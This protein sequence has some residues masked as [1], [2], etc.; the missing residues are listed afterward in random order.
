M[1]PHRPSQEPTG[2]RRCATALPQ[3]G[4]APLA[5]AA[6]GLLW[7]AT[8]AAWPVIAAV[9]A[10]VAVALTV[11]GPRGRVVGLAALLS[12]LAGLPQAGRQREHRPARFLEGTAVVRHA[13]LPYRGQQ[14]VRV[15][16]DG[17]AGQAVELLLPLQWDG[18]GVAHGA[19]LRVTCRRDGRRRMR[20][21]SRS[22]WARLQAA[23]PLRRLLH[24]MRCQCARSFERH[25]PR[26][27]AAWARALLLGDR[28]ALPFPVVKQLRDT[29][30]GHLLAV[31]GLHVG[32]VLALVMAVLR[33]LPLSPPNQA[34]VALPMVLCVVP[35]MG[36]PPSAVRAGVAACLLLLA[37][38]RGHCAGAWPIV[39]ATGAVVLL[40]SPHMAH[41]LSARLSF[42]AALGIVL[43]RR[44]LLHALAPPPPLVLPGLLDASPRR[45]RVALALACSAWLGTLPWA[46]T[47]FGRMAWLGP[48]LSL[49]LVP[50][51]ALFLGALP[52]ALLAAQV[53]G[54]EGAAGL[55]IETVRAPLVLL[56]T[57]AAQWG[58]EARPAGA[59]PL[60]LV[61][62]G[63]ACAALA[64]APT[65]RRARWACVAVAGVLA[66]ALGHPP[67]QR[68]APVSLPL[69]Q[70]APMPPTYPEPML[71]L[72]LL[73]G[74]AG[75]AWAAARPL[76][77]LTP[78]GA[79]AA[80]ALGA[81]SL[82]LGVPAWAALFA[83]F[84]AAS[85]AGRLPGARRH[86][87][88]GLAQVAA[89]GL[90]SALGA[91]CVACGIAEL[92]EAIFVGGLAFLGADTL[93]TELGIRYGGRPRALL[94]GRALAPGDSGGV[95]WIGSL[96][97]LG[98]A[99]LA[100]FAYVAAGGRS[101][102][103]SLAWAL[104]VASAG[105]CGAVVDSV[106]GATLQFRG[107]DP[108]TGEATETRGAHILRRRGWRWLG[109]D[110][111]NLVGAV[112]AA[113]LA[114]AL[115]TRLIG[116]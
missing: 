45:V 21:V 67:P 63:A 10:F 94:S 111:V 37:R 99:C 32:L 20:L 47:V 59:S 82:V 86:G 12:L 58:G 110:E 108:A 57:L 112:A 39:L 38:A 70:N 75:F 79:A 89:N 15:H 41:D 74:L 42:S 26:D 8:A 87:R 101:G 100:P 1:S 19:R 43:L 33:A 80:W 85:V 13:G 105:A 91:I 116:G 6:L 53:P 93:A 114:G 54:L 90:T 28:E 104:L 61:A 98:G 55:C 62:Y 14:R 106:L 84:V 34:R 103:A 109:N 78:R 76:R 72:A 88:R 3:L 9:S 18:L 35:M 52:L 5:A 48:L 25:L 107:Q 102:D 22:A 77:L 17:G 83:P 23:A 95:T 31:S 49:I 44:P 16:F 66:C 97:M 113:L 24:R 115:V 68:A 36:A 65:A 64:T 4:E 50:C 73:L 46:L 71:A 29:G 2:N 69:A 56:P 27:T 7:G 60:L 51:L 11:A 40:G 92:G 81:L 30:Q 96:A